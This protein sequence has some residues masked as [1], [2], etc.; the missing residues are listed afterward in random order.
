MLFDGVFLCCLILSRALFS[1]CFI[2]VFCFSGPGVQPTATA[3]VLGDHARAGTPVVR[4][5]RHYAVVGLRCLPFV[6][7]HASVNLVSCFF[8]FFHHAVVVSKSVGS[9][10]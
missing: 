4:Q 2:F 8:F 6:Y 3:G 7:L 5:P 10:M 1:V 9:A